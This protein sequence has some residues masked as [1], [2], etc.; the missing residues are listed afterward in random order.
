MPSDAG[1]SIAGAGITTASSA[2]SEGAATNAAIATAPMAAAHSERRLNWLRD[3][4]FLSGEQIWVS[5]CRWQCRA[6]TA[7]RNRYGPPD[8]R[9]YAARRVLLQHEAHEFVNKSP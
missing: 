3:M 1:A 2:A 4:G 7:V 8:V 9:K 6:A 5:G